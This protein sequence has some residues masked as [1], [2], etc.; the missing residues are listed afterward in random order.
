M[1]YTIK[2]H[3]DQYQLWIRINNQYSQVF[4]FETQKDAEIAKQE[5]IAADEERLADITTINDYFRVEA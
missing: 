3:N 4:T 1:R 5:A 2:K